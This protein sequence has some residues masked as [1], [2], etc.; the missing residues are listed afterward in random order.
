VCAS[1]ALL[2]RMPEDEACSRLVVAAFFGHAP[3]RT[4]FVSLALELQNVLARRPP[5]D[6]RSLSLAWLMLALHA[7]RELATDASS[8]ER[9]DLPLAELQV[10][11]PALLG[12]PSR[13]R[14]ARHAQPTGVP[15]PARSKRS[16]IA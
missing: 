10:P 14:P 16:L 1:A 12:W 13:F 3:W 6:K 15:C 4:R 9:V 5:V 8:M 11:Q 7:E 2:A